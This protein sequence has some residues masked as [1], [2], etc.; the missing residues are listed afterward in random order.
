MKIAPPAVLLLLAVASLSA[1]NQTPTVNATPRALTARPGTG[2]VRLFLG[3]VFRDADLQSL[4]GTQ[5]RVST[6]LG[7]INLELFDRTAPRTVTNFLGY[8][9][10]GRYGNV[11]WHRR[12]NSANPFVQTID[13]GAYAFSGGSFAAVPAFAPLANEFGASNVRGTVAMNRPTGSPDGATSAW[14]INRGDNQTLLDAFEGGFTVFGRVIEGG[15]TVVDNIFALPTGNLGTD[16]ELM[17]L[18]NFAGGTPTSANFVF[19]DAIATGPKFVVSASSSD[20]NIAALASPAAAAD[21]SST[22]TFG[23][24]SGT[25]QI[26]LTGTDFNGAFA[27]TSFSVT[28]GNAP[29]QTNL[30]NISTRARVGTGENVLI[31]GFV[32][33][34]NAKQ[35]LVRA[36]GPSL[37]AFGVQGALANPQIELR[38]GGS[39]V[40]TNDDWR[41]TQQAA[42]QASGFAPANDLDAALIATLPPGSYTPI[43]SGV[44]GAAGVAIVEVYE[45]AVNEAPRLINLSSRGRV[46]TGEDVMIGGFVIN[47]STP[48]R[49]L[50][51]A[52]GPSLTPFGVAGA[53][54][55]PKLELFAGA[56][57]LAGNDDWRLASGGGANPD[58]AAIQASGFAPANDKESAVLLTLAPGAYTAIVRGVG[59]TAGVAIIE[60]YDLD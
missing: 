6:P 46:G 50:V 44:G 38:S 3:D 45:L 18:R 30:A 10:A 51:R 11:V 39:V 59:E 1:Q 58:L 14:F 7:A 33:R 25:A 37:T 48:K 23:P 40:A 32:V 41:A 29:A 8:V 2:A 9:S 4:S 53:L 21:F 20:P 47:G 60:V 24:N 16:R 35:V 28:V 55:D 57:F 43:V 12:T 5:A 19:L 13:T 54:A 56:N 52:A 22:L 27:Q 31:G 42:I 36:L 34:D 15:M 17:P 49:V 26:T